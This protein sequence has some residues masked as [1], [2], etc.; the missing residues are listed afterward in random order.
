LP[1]HVGFIFLKLRDGDHGNSVR[2]REASP[3]LIRYRGQ[4]KH[5]RDR[6]KETEWIRSV[7]YGVHDGKGDYEVMDWAACRKLTGPEAMRLE[8]IEEEDIDNWGQF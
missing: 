3:W 8:E 6:L 4:T 7:E 1:L 2:A 5:M